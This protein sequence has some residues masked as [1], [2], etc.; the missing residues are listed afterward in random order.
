MELQ[1]TSYVLMLIIAQLCFPAP[2]F[3]LSTLNCVTELPSHVPVIDSQDFT[4]CNLIHT[5]T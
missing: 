5:K 1:V 3:S 2:A 4:L